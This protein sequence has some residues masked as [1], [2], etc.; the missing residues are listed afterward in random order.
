MADDA[1][2]EKFEKWVVKRWLADPTNQ[3]NLQGVHMLASTHDSI[4]C[5]T[6][7]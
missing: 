4:T 3:P 6:D 1:L 2:R 7:E 5:E